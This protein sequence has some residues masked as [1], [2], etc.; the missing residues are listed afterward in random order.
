MSLYC[1]GKYSDFRKNTTMTTKWAPLV[2]GQT[3]FSF[4]IA[5][6]LFHPKDWGESQV[7]SFEETIENIR[8]TTK[9]NTLSHQVVI[10]TPEHT[11]V[12]IMAP[13]AEMV[14][15]D[16]DKTKKLRYSHLYDKEASPSPTNPKVATVKDGSRE[17]LFAWDFNE[18]TKKRTNEKGVELVLKKGQS[19]KNGMLIHD[20]DVVA[21]LKTKGF[22]GFVAKGHP[23]E[24]PDLR[25]KKI[26]QPLFNHTVEKYDRIADTFN[27]HSTP[28]KYKLTPAK[29]I[30]IA[31]I[32]KLAAD[33]A[34]SAFTGEAKNGVSLI[35][36]K[37]QK[38]SAEAWKNI[39]AL[40]TGNAPGEGHAAAFSRIADKKN[41][42]LIDTSN[43]PGE[44][45]I[46][47][48]I[49]TA[50]KELS[51]ER[52]HGTTSQT[53]V[54]PEIAV[55]EVVTP[56][57]VTTSTNTTQRT[58][59]AVS[60]GNSFLK[61]LLYDSKNTG[62]MHMGKAAGWAA[63][64]AGIGALAYSK[65][66]KAPPPAATAQPWQNR[67]TLPTKPTIERS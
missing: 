54:A 6:P 25:D 35:L 12:G 53:T 22:W 31:E 1:Q 47:Q 51:P 24:I 38:I 60:E 64:A 8:E 11:I 40:L 16:W 36:Q 56:E 5:K 27:E 67:I 18:K 4:L 2:Q 13:N 43:K 7:D 42:S 50:I 44:G 29:Q 23:K 3:G 41:P 59:A 62:K 15:A 46:R 48:R 45:T 28:K 37:T 26:F 34:N 66:E 61:N 58:S 21:G 33:S 63:V 17:A 39:H 19:I 32:E 65:S 57:P 14:P 52:S 9:N 55:P 10:R 20:V 49:S 30:S